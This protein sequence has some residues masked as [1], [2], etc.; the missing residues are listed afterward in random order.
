MVKKAL[1]VFRHGGHFLLVNLGMLFKRLQVTT[2]KQE[3]KTI[4]L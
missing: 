4:I 3:R 2:V 1:A